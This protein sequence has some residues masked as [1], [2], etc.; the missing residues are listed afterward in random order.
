MP[1]GTT[2]RE[3][4]EGLE[5]DQ[6]QYEEIDNYCKAKNIIWF[7]S[8]PETDSLDFLYQFDLKSNK[9]ASA[10]IVD[11][12][13]LNQ[14]AL[15]KKHT[16]ISTGMSTVENIK[17]AVNIFKKMIVLLNLCIAYQLTLANQKM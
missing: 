4:K 13:F 6:S 8:A 9:I 15:R 11:Y 7:L 12:N 10:M 2:Q 5:F 16:F 14:V 17:N 1:W 3:Q